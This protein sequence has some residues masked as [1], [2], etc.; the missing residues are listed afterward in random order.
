MKRKIFRLLILALLTLPFSAIAQ[1][2]LQR[3]NVSFN[4]FFDYDSSL[5][6]VKGNYYIFKERPSTQF[7]IHCFDQ[8]VQPDSVKLHKYLKQTP[9]KFKE[10]SKDSAAMDSAMKTDN[11]VTDLGRIA[12]D[13]GFYG[14][15]KAQKKKDEEGS[16]NTLSFD[17]Y[18]YDDHCFC[19]FK[20]R[21]NFGEEPVD[22]SDT[23]LVNRFVSRLVTRSMKEVREE[24]QA[25]RDRYSI[26][27]DTLALE[28]YWIHVYSKGGKLT[29]DS[30]FMHQLDSVDFKP[31]FTHYNISYRANLIVEPQLE[32]NFREFYLDN[33][34]KME[35]RGDTFY[36]EVRDAK[37]G[38]ISRRGTITIENSLGYPIDLPFYINY[39]NHLYERLR[40]VR[41]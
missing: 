38:L 30:I 36:I 8:E 15:Y 10:L 40:R 4:S 23:A 19:E 6:N 29:R 17:T 7:E 31:R 11:A 12:F 25:I 3:V 22:F 1:N 32:H 20:Y 14:L 34:K 18:N 41:N 28:N 27:I 13:R 35:Q 37:A 5:F 16:F 9:A 2:T 26:K 21:R 39:R 24:N 33:L